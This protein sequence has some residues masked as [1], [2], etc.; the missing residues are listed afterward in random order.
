[1]SNKFEQLLDYLVNE[2]TDKAN[3]LFHEIVVEK[4]REI[5]GNL[6]AEEVDDDEMDEAK[7]EEAA[8]ESKEEDDE[9]M[10]ESKKEEEEEADESVKENFGDQEESMYEIGGDPADALVGDVKDPDAMGMDGAETDGAMDG[11]DMGGADMGGADMGGSEPASKDDVLDI[12]DALAELTAEFQA[13]LAGE[14][15]EEEGDPDMHGGE[16]DGMGS[17]DDAE[18]DM[19]ADDAEV[20]MDADDA[21]DDDEGEEEFGKKE[22]DADEN[23]M[24]EY[25]ETVGKPYGG[26]KGVSGKTEEASTNKTSV[27]AS[28]K[29]KPTAGHTGGATAKNIAQDGK[30]GGNEDGTS[31]KGKVGGVLKKGGE[32]VAKGTHNV[33]GKE[34]GVKT[35]SKVAA[36]HGAEKKGAGEKQVNTKDILPGK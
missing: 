19:D 2:E 27:V 35:L 33:D 16:L 36:G 30:G 34:S 17:D 10:D 23:F 20:D 29:G 31:P 32:F 8:D 25:R 7:E 3:E 24:R 4:S 21:A 15:H 28:G 1:M 5:Y 13:L 26:G 9:E 12:K 11:A 6:I 18:V 22:T 14:K